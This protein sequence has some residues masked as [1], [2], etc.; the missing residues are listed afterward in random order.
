MKQAEAEA[1]NVSAEAAEAARAFPAPP[2]G[3][4]DAVPLQPTCGSILVVDIIHQEGLFRFSKSLAKKKAAAAA[5][6]LGVT[7]S[8][9]VPLGSVQAEL[10]F[11]Q[12]LPRLDSGDPVLSSALKVQ[13]EDVSES[14]RGSAVLGVNPVLSHAECKFIS[15]CI[16]I[17]FY[18]PARSYCAPLF[19]SAQWPL[20][21][22]SARRD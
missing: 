18:L 21:P 6:V 4:S 8:P 10:R 20:H 3:L 2:K 11:F 1:R 5:R 16:Y 19:T 9:W 12:Q 22:G 7:R 15:K 17:F 13:P 14:I